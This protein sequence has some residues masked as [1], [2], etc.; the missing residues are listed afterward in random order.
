MGVLTTDY[1]FLRVIR[2]YKVAYNGTGFVHI[3]L[4][5]NLADTFF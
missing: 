1:F 2:N 3:L 5:L 4:M